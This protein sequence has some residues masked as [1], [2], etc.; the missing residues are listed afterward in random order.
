M[1][2]SGASL[3]SLKSLGNTGFDIAVEFTGGG[4]RFVLVRVGNVMSAD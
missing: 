1:L 4:D 2:R 3:F